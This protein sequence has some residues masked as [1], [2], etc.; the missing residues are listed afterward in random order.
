[1]TRVTSALLRIGDA[2]T[3]GEDDEVVSYPLQLIRENDL[4]KME[5]ARLDALIQGT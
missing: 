5:Y 2:L 4:W 1:M 3:E